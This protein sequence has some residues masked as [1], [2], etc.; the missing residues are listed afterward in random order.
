L[1]LRLI[2]E[3]LWE[4]RTAQRC[5]RLPILAISIVNRLILNASEFSDRRSQER[6]ETGTTGACCAGNAQQF[7]RTVSS[8]SGQ[9]SVGLGHGQLTIDILRI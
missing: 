9:W 8:V 1:S 4:L 3:M 6:L 2:K 7:N 5:P